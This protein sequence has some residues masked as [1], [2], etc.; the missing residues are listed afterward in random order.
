[1]PRQACWLPIFV[2]LFIAF[3]NQALSDRA[4]IAG[5]APTY[6]QRVLST[7]N[8]AG[9]IRQRMWLPGIDRGDVPQGLTVTEDAVILATYNSEG[10]TPKCRLYRI[11]PARLEVMGHFDMPANC[12]H[13]G[14]AAYAGGGR[15]F[16]SDTW[17]IYEIAYPRAFDGAADA[18]VKSVSL[19]FPLKGSFLAAR[20]D[21]LWLGEYKKPQPGKLW[22]IPL[23]AFEAAEEPAGLAVAAARRQLVVAPMTQGAAFDAAG[24]LWLSQ[25]NSQVGGLQ[26]VDPDTGAVL[27]QY[28]AFAGLEDIGFG[29]DGLLWTSSEAGTR[30]WHNWPSF[31]PLLFAIDVGALK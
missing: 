12:G 16:V 8:I 28:R 11:D 5:T 24:R 14:G 29:A 17:R 31:Y 15:L 6:S 26:Q 4:P 20:S 7:P 23:A 19:R 21:A 13:A 10:E 22:E 25:S 2:A 9:A 30:R 27:A 1:M 18:V 3:A